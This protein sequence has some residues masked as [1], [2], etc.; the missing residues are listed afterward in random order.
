M[1]TDLIY[2]QPYHEYRSHDSFGSTDL[3]NMT[4]SLR[5]F[6]DGRHNPI[7]ETKSM[8]FGSLMHTL[9]LEEDFFEK[10]Y[11]VFPKTRRH[12]EYKEFCE[13]NYNKIIITKSEHDRAITCIDKIKDHPIMSH[14]TGSASEVSVYGE[15]SEIPCKGRLDL[16]N[17][18]YD[19]FDAIIL[20]FKSIRSIRNW[21][22]HCYEYGYHIQ[23][24]VYTSLLKQALKKEDAIIKMFFVLFET[25]KDRYYIAVRE[26]DEDSRE[27]ASAQVND[28]LIDYKHAMRDGVDLSKIDPYES[29]LVEGVP[30]WAIAKYYNSI[31]A[32]L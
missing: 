4:I 19:D 1:K 22:N 28:A 31:G 26:I 10:R 21:S 24:Y 16:L 20:D 15:I 29:P 11:A 25:E 14:F 30:A 13:E 2:N 9:I 8:Q 23:E 12:K 32:E 27:L 6:W 18:N 5:H 3:K 7:E 17:T